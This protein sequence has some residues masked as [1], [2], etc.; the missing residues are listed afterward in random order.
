[1][2]GNQLILITTVKGVSR[3]GEQAAQIGDFTNAQGAEHVSRRPL[4]EVKNK[5]ST[6][7]GANRPRLPLLASSS[8][9]TT[10][11]RQPY[12]CCAA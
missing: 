9:T 10:G 5:G 4:E 8:E 1:M 12:C 2:R 6:E 7:P 11:K 3:T